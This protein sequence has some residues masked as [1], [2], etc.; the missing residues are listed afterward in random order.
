MYIIDKGQYMYPTFKYRDFIVGFDLKY[1]C[2][3]SM[4]GL[5]EKRNMNYLLHLG[6]S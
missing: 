6:I 1:T 5:I 3:I 4:S 2:D